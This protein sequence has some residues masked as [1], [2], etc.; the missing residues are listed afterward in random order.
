MKKSLVIIFLLALM[1]SFAQKQ[2]NIWYFG[3]NAGLDFNTSPPTALT[4]GSINTLEGCSTFSDKDGNLLFYSDGITVWD[5]NHTVMKYTDGRLANN[6]RGDPSS[7]QSGMIIPKPKSDTI[8]YL[9]TVDDGPNGPSLPA[10]GL[11]LYTIDI[12]KNGGTGEI[13]DGPINISSG[14]EDLW[15]EKVA[16]VRGKEC[17]TFWVI[18]AVDN[19][20]HAFKIDDTGVNITPV[21]STVSNFATRRGYLKL[22]PD[23][24]KLAIANQLGNAMLYDFD[25]NT[26]KVDNS[27]T[28]LTNFTDGN[29][30]GVEFSVDSRKLYISTVSSFRLDLE[31]PPTTYKLFHYD[32]NTSNIFESKTLIHTQTPGFRGGLQLGPD[33][34]IYVTIPLAYNDSEGDAESLDVIENPTAEA[35]DVIFT[36]D[37]ID[38][39]GKLSTQGFPPFISSLLLP[40]EIIDNSSSE[41]IN[42]QDRQHCIGESI[43]I[44]SGSV[45]GTGITYEW[46]FDN[47]VT[48]SVLSNTST[49][50][51]NNLTTS[52]NGTYLLTVTLTNDCGDVT[53]L[54]G[55]FNLE[56]F[57]PATANPISD[58]NF[59]DLDGDGFNTFDFQTDL[60]PIVVGAQDPSKFEVLYFNNRTDADTNNT[61]NA[62]P[63]PYTNTVPFINQNI[64]VR[65]NN[66]GAP[67]ACY[68]TTEFNL[69]VTGI[70]KP[71]QPLDYENCDDIVS[72]GD[73]DG[74][75][76]N[77]IL[78]SKD[79]E[80]LGALSSTQY[81]VTYHTTLIGAQTDS[82]TDLIDK[83]IPYRNV[84]IN[85][86]T[87]YVRVE[88]VDNINC[89]VISDPLSTTFKP[90]KLV[91]NLLPVIINDP[92]EIKQCDIDI[93]LATTIN[94][95]QAQISISNNYLNETFKYYPS[96]IDANNDTREITNP[97]N[98][99]TSDGDVIWVRT[100]SSKNCFRV[101]KLN[102]TV[103]F[104]PDI[105]YNK[106]FTACDD[107]LDI[108][109][110]DT[111][112]NDDNDGIS[113]F[114]LSKT[115]TEIK[116]LFPVSIRANL[117]VLLF[118]TVND[119]D[120]VINQISNVTNYRN[121]NIP[122]FTPQPIYVKII[123]KINNDCTGLG[124]FSIKVNPL[125]NFDITSPQITCLNAPSFIEAETPDGNYNYQWR[126]NGNLSIIGTNQ[127]LNI[128]NG[129]V[130]EVTAINT[131]TKCSRSKT[132]TISES[133]IATINQEDV[134]IVD[135]SKNNTISINNNGTNLG[136]GD[137]EFA[138]Q[139]QSKRIIQNFQDEPF[140]ENLQG[141]IYTILV[142][143][144]NNCGVAELD[145]SVLE[146]PKFFTPNADGVNDLWNVKGASTTFYPQSSMHIFDRYGKTITSLQ[147]D[148][149]GWNGLFNG[150]M[151]PST[152]YWFKITLTDL[153]G[154]TINRQGN[155]SLLRK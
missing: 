16:A 1:N 59:C 130:Y 55:D 145:V 94:L 86:Q 11:N 35:R 6:L 61:I 72:G 40:I 7:T 66:K 56:V 125:P 142:R 141:G 5:K 48:T 18:S 42:N 74:F 101:S 116:E 147:I 139:D 49:L 26:G 24:T 38:L 127:Q 2:A 153:N 17:D 129:G 100:I 110:N 83:N 148:G 58:I 51:I 41:I 60:T 68:D 106:E 67:N 20:F 111:V 37:A 87:I 113:N 140:F 25:A 99:A 50:K 84:S 15:T 138:L 93:D 39:N 103:S 33:S 98:Y 14:L 134:T 75:F 28:V 85:E 102:I 109:G 31:A 43:E 122:A 65:I 45:T 117:N 132:I 46:S 112:N 47:G 107:F 88:N 114:N 64:Y 124:E 63:N 149:E 79:A 143:D 71:N 126:K 151:L 131:I 133:I 53:I 92:A 150:K 81:K 69:M 90:F 52:D 22:S 27:G 54:E 91:V 104:I 135:D 120:A 137:Y 62:L 77:Y 136:I 118:E 3:R 96:E 89:V 21:I 97:I 73:T 121:L 29:S 30:Y 82:F 23:G 108:D 146:F 105:T 9:F 10:F 36:K 19:K 123:N 76:N 12:S 70:P 44:S 80:I 34:K 13:I 144:K 4:D 78:A 119:R 57:D 115:I 32:L 8:F 128:T 152:D 95:T 154:N 155:F